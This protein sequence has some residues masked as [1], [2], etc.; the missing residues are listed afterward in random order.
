MS[1]WCLCWGATHCSV[2]SI[3]QLSVGVMYEMAKCSL[4][5]W[6]DDLKWFSDFTAARKSKMRN[7]LVLQ[8][9]RD[10]IIC[11]RVCVGW[12]LPHPQAWTKVSDSPEHKRSRK[13]KQSNTEETWDWIS[14]DFRIRG[15]EEELARMGMEVY[16]EPQDPEGGGKCVWAESGKMRRSILLPPEDWSEESEGRMK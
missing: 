9:L 13:E 3:P 12:T 16:R 7:L 10:I 5:I 2:C 14:G 8:S 15:G 6:C 1:H 4:L 11:V